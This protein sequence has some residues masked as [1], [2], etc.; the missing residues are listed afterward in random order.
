ML[1]LALILMFEVVPHVRPSNTTKAVEMTKTLVDML[2]EIMEPRHSHDLGKVLTWSYETPSPTVFKLY[3]DTNFTAL[4]V[5]TTFLQTTIT[6]PWLVQHFVEELG[7]LANQCTTNFKKSLCITTTPWD[8]LVGMLC[9][10]SSLPHPSSLSGIQLFQ[11]FRLSC[12]E[13]KDFY[14]LVQE[15]K[16]V[17][18]LP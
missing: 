5:E 14:S 3:Y 2:Q 9:Y 7:K 8:G 10:E 6:S 13:I 4:S 11:L 15:L 18:N 1:L 17:P 12:R 16:S